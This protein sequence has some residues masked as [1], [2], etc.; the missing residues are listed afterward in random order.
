MQD[1]DVELTGALS[2]AAPWRVSASDVSNQV[3]QDTEAELLSEP[4]GQWELV[5]RRFIRH[6]LALAGA[7][8]MGVLVFVAIF[9]PMISPESPLGFDYTAGNKP[10]ELSWRYLLGTDAF[11]HSV[12]MYILYGARVS[13]EV[14]IF[15]TTLTS[16]IGVI[17][18]SI[19][20]YF[21]GFVDGIAMR[22]TDVFLTLPFLPLLI[23]L[24]AYTGSG[25]I[26]FIVII[27]GCISWPAIAR[28]VRSYFLTLREREFVDAAHAIGVSSVRIMFRH[29]LPN[30]LSVVIVAATLQI[31]FFIVAEA[32]IDFLGI[33]IHS[34]QVSWGLAL[35]NSQD[36]IE[37]GNWWWPLFP[38]L[39]LLLTVLAANFLG[40]GLRDALDVHSKVE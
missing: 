13:L 11:G 25:N 31:A 16:V 23:L 17:V 21:S 26:W 27:F 34:P 35:A 4:I 15:A 33:G 18:G 39:A 6:R 20:G 8:I 22:L 3:L 5:W 30:A 28:L 7:V 2:Q 24:S 12:L 37:Q 9:G 36:Y 40:D 38:G 1:P 10:P 32:A 29:M 19:A 14:G